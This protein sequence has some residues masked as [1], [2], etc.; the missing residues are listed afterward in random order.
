MDDH[1]PRTDDAC[2]SE[3]IGPDHRG[4]WTGIHAG[5]AVWRKELSGRPARH[6]PSNAALFAENPYEYSRTITL[7]R[8]IPRQFY[9]LADEEASLGILG[10]RVCLFAA[11]LLSGGDELQRLSIIDGES[12]Q[13]LHVYEIRILP[14]TGNGYFK[15]API[16]EHYVRGERYRMRLEFTDLAADAWEYSFTFEGAPPGVASAALP[17]LISEFEYARETPSCDALDEAAFA[18][19][20][21]TAMPGAGYPPYTVGDSREREFCIKIARD[22]RGDRDTLEFWLSGLT[23]AS[24]DCPSGFDGTGHPACTDG[25][26]RFT[27]DLNIIGGLA[28]RIRERI[29]SCGDDPEDLL[30]LR[31]VLNLFCNGLGVKCDS[32]LFFNLVIIIIAVGIATVPLFGGWA[33]VGEITVLHAVLAYLLLISVLVLGVLLVGLPEYQAAIPII[34]A[35][36]GGLLVLYGRL[37]SRT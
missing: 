22:D 7:D 10:F 30:C 2:G 3:S 14:G 27:A 37:R 32:E 20:A 36:V 13:I 17:V 33:T 1:I 24:A 19:R 29:P 5:P 9:N 4:Q 35:T 12:K 26:K 21:P 11:T 23:L 28:D 6:E 25:L 16:A 8:G 18:D 31:Q 15:L 34:I